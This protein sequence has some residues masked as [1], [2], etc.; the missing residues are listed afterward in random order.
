MIG[1]GAAAHGY[2]VKFC[3]MEVRLA[4]GRKNASFILQNFSMDLSLPGGHS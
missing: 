4:W 3:K 2:G 1:A